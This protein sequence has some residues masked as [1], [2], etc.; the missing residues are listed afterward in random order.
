MTL[1]ILVISRSLREPVRKKRKMHE[2][3]HSQRF[4]ISFWRQPA[5]QHALCVCVFSRGINE[6][7]NNFSFYY[8]AEE[9]SCVSPG[10]LSGSN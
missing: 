1:R 9:F 10:T 2:H 7:W 4:I 8:S 6:P 3:P 5:E